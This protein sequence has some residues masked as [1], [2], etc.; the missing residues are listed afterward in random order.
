MPRPLNQSKRRNIL[1]LNGKEYVVSGPVQEQPASEFATQINQGDQRYD[2]RQNASFWSMSSWTGGAGV[3]YGNHREHQ[4]RFYDSDG[5]DT[6][7]PNQLTLGPL[8]Q[9]VTAGASSFSTQ[10]TVSSTMRASF[11]SYKSNDYVG[12]ADKVYRLSDLSTAVLDTGSSIVLTQLTSFIDSSG[13]NAI[14]AFSHSNRFWT[15]TTGAAAS[16]TQSDSGVLGRFAFEYDRNL[17]LLDGIT[18]L[19][20]IS[21]YTSGTRGA[22]ASWNETYPEFRTGG[23]SLIS[24]LTFMNRAG[25]PTPFFAMADTTGGNLSGLY[26]LDFYARKAYPIP[27]PRTPQRSFEINES[28]FGMAVWNGDLYIP[29]RQ[30]LLRYRADGS[31]SDLSTDSGIGQGLAPGYGTYGFLAPAGSFLYVTMGSGSTWAIGA[32]SQGGFHFLA[33][34]T[35]PI[36]GIHISTLQSPSRLYWCK[37]ATSGTSATVDYIELPVGSENPV[38]DSTYKYAASNTL[39]TFGTDLGFADIDKILLRMSIDA[40]GLS[41]DETVKVEYQVNTASSNGIS[42][43]GAWTTLGTFNSTT[44]KL[45]WASGAGIVC[46]AIRFRYTLARGSTNTLTPK[47][48]SITLQYLVTPDY[49]PQKQLSIDIEETLRERG[50]THQDAATIISELKTAYNADTLVTYKYG[51]DAS[52]YVKVVTYPFA[53]FDNENGRRG[54]RVTLQVLEPLAG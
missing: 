18:R 35:T 48:R 50:A 34:T 37:A 44:R 33:K 40:E 45:D 10:E 8:V 46:R 32:Q 22:A 6:R 41:S 19:G 16:W 54:G 9:T 20:Q 4:G 25:E 17:I 12:L 15:S 36:R 1:L 26:T 38:N 7:F 28:F 49:R 51:N 43:G 29:D 42:D 52:T 23:T 39:T 11:T 31:V 14:Y 3:Y 24:G 2:T 30:N 47:V 27:L 21:A 5:A 53:Q 13:N